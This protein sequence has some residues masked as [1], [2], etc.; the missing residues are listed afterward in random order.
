M[1]EIMYNIMYEIMYNI[2]CEIIRNNHHNYLLIKC[3]KLNKMM[4]INNI[5]FEK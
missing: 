1:Y 5:N 3:I 4:C 2:M